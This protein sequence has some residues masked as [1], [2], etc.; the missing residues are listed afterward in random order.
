MGSFGFWQKW[1]FNFGLYL[2]AFGF[3]LAFF[4]RSAL[5]DFVFNNQID[6]AFWDSTELPENA[7]RFRAWIYGVLGA[8]IDGWG[9]FVSFIVYYTFNT[10][11]RWAWNCIATGFVVW[12]IIDTII[13]VYYGVGFNVFINIAFI[14]FVSL[15]LLFTRKYFKVN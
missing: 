3:V 1:L 15:P 5:L 9:I 2:I 6:P 14:L 10:K 4:S 13:S 11:E 12:F 7:E 8:V